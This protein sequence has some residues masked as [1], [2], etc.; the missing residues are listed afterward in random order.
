MTAP[1][2]LQPIAV[3]NPPFWPE[4]FP[5]GT[6]EHELYEV[7]PILPQPH[8]PADLDAIAG[9]WIAWMPRH[10]TQ[11]IELTTEKYNPDNPDDPRR[12]L[13]YVGP[14]NEV[15]DPDKPTDP[16]AGDP[17]PGWWYPTPHGAYV[18]LVHSHAWG[19]TVGSFAADGKPAVLVGTAPSYGRRPSPIWRRLEESDTPPDDNPSGR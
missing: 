11:K 4:K 9:T 1:A 18:Y 2:T 15:I 19:L 3:E 5:P 7:Q 12:K 6:T 13:T 8:K 17:E 16:F 10:Q 14:Y